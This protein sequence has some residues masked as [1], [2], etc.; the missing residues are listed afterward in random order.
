MGDARLIGANS[1]PLERLLAGENASDVTPSEP[2][3]PTEEKVEPTEE[4]VE[5]TNNKRR[6]P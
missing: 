5:E 1:V 2:T 3:S 6:K 4:Q